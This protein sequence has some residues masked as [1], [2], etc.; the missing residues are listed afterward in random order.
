MECLPRPHRY[1]PR[2]HPPE[3]AATCKCTCKQ[4]DEREPYCVC[5]G[6]AR[7]FASESAVRPGRRALTIT[8]RFCF[9]NNSLRFDLPFAERGEREGIHSAIQLRSNYSRNQLHRRFRFF[10]PSFLPT[11]SMFHLALPNRDRSMLL[12]LLLLRL[13]FGDSTNH[14]DRFPEIGSEPIECASNVGGAASR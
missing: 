14:Q 3:R 11:R 10:L 2:S 7:T 6:D 1:R 5:G 13:R 9:F 8:L 12:L 4:R